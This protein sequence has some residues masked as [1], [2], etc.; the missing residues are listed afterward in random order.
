MTKRRRRS[1]EPPVEVA[2]ETSGLAKSYGDLDALAPLDLSIPAG[3]VVAVVG[4][5][6]SGKSTLLQLTAGL[7]DATT[8][9]VEVHGHPAGSR[10]A[11]AAVSYIGDTPVL[12]D[13]LSVW[14]HL[15]YL[16]RLHGVTEWEHRSRDLLERF[17]LTERAEDL[18]VQFSRGLRQ[19]TALILGLV[20][21]ARLLLIDEPFVGLDARGKD[22][23]LGVIGE[24]RARDATV[25]VATHD[26]EILDTVD[27][28][29]AL[30]NGTV[31]HDGDTAQPSITGL[32]G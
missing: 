7:L 23:L 18:P 31:T 5:N 1:P 12:Y 4:H 2:L 6:G 32:V 20:R 21:E 28:C 15:E 22:E 13:D 8:G 10:N 30:H 24:Q 16:S 26:L 3:Q 17:D 29:I 9:T 14:E 11:R 19:K 25:V 27:R